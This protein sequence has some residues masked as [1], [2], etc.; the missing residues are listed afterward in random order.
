MNF[1]EFYDLYLQIRQR[2]KLII[3]MVDTTV[4]ID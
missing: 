3:D 2:H 1:D 4:I